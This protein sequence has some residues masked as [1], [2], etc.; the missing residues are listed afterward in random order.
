MS[1][2]GSSQFPANARSAAAL[3]ELAVQRAKIIATAK[4]E[5]VTEEL[6]NLQKPVRLEGIVSEITRD[7][8]ITIQ[9]EK[10]S[11]QIQPRQQLPLTEGQKVIV[12]LPAGQPPAQIT[13]TPALPAQAPSTPS[14]STPP[15]YPPYPQNLGQTQIQKPQQNSIQQ[16]SA[17]PTDPDVIIAETLQQKILPAIPPEIAARILLYESLTELISPE[18]PRPLE[19]GETVRLVPLPLAGAQQEPITGQQQKPES[20]AVP[21]PGFLNP[22][23]DNFKNP[24]IQR[25]VQVANVTRSVVEST[26]TFFQVKPLPASDPVSGGA[27]ITL[28]GKPAAPDQQETRQAFQIQGSF[29]ARILSVTPPGI[30]I[31]KQNTTQ[32]IDTPA[33]SLKASI[34]SITKQNHP[35]ITIGFQPDMKTDFFILQFPSSNTPV[36]TQIKVMPQTETVF[37]SPPPTSQAVS[38]TPPFAPIELFS[39]WTWPDFEE[40][41]TILARQGGTGA[42]QNFTNMIP[43]PATPAK[44]PPAILFL[45]AAIGAGDAAGWMG[46]KTL[47]ILR[48]DGAKGSDVLSRLTRDFSGLSRILSD[49]ATQDWKSMTLPL[50]WQNEIQKIHVHFR[51]QNGGEKDSNHPKGGSTRF[52]FDLHLDQ[53]GNVQLDGLMREKRLDLILRTETPFSHVMQSTI[54]QKYLDVLETGNLSGDL[55]FQNRMGQFV[56]VDIR[57]SNIGVNA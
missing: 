11:I 40:T 19:P 57:H 42:V 29:D 6:T 33:G 25:V 50:S 24:V 18:K 16:V 44:I 46:E 13:L 37:H 8:R 39:T 23:A 27:G 9:T 35:V 54:R 12:D 56:K 2:S 31:P 52:I 5:K 43:N 48:R 32:P 3:A 22:I 34:V 10:G 4:V 36:G 14:A 49:T 26:V 1:D 30:N 17:Y 28:T 51:K 7:G 21:L 55:A 20:P 38:T 53:M 15:S 47:N 41:V 45:F